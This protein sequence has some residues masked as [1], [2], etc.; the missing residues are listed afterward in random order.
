[1]NTADHELAAIE[2]VSARATALTRWASAVILIPGVLVIFPLYLVAR[3]IQFA[4]I[5][6]NIPYVSGA[7]AVALGLGPSIFLARL[8]CRYLVRLKRPGWIEQ[9]SREHGVSPASIAESFGEWNG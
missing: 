7:V 1:M 6:V 9:A 4:A 3:Q 5:G 2:S 8:V